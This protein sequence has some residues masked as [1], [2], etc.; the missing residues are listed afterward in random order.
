MK[1]NRVIF[2]WT[3]IISI[4]CMIVLPSLFSKGMFLDGVTYASISRNLA[5]GNGSILHPYYTESLYP[6]FHEQPPFFFLIQS[7]FFKVL[8]DFIWVERIFSAI[9]LIF[10]I[11]GIKLLWE[12]LYEKE[13]IYKNSY[14]PVLLFLTT[15]IVI[16][17]FQNNIIENLLIPLSIFSVYFLLLEGKKYDFNLIVSASL[18]VISFFTKGPVGLFPLT[19]PL[20]IW[21]F[22]NKPIRQ[23]LTFYLSFF[24]LIIIAFLVEDIRQNFLLFLE[25]QLF[26]AIAGKREVTT[27]TRFKIL[28]KLFLE[29][30][31]PISLTILTLIVLRNRVFLK[32][33]KGLLFVA[34]GLSASVPLMITLKQRSHYI[35]P[36]IPF[37][38]I[39]FSI[40]IM[41]FLGK[42]EK[43]VKRKVLFILP[44]SL[45]FTSISLMI[46][47]KGQ[48]L[49]DIK[50]Q[51]D[52]EILN[53][54]TKF[55][56]SID[57]DI[58]SDWGLHAYAQRYYQKSFNVSDNKTFRLLKKE[59]NLP[60]GFLS[61][62][63][64]LNRYQLAQKIN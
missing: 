20:F 23:F 18:L 52:L 64:K 34:I 54:K 7:F 32:N 8:G 10:S 35:L 2:F 49:R 39:G 22:L 14:L 45:F 60:K 28:Y 11:F 29:L 36:S 16:W 9:L 4:F 21:Y 15:P 62:D 26:P 13:P 12:K 17:S 59:K 48:K 5:F 55:D 44:L 61:T 3:L 51:I 43:H 33:G 50:L 6:K 30:L 25:N 46:S 40:F 37:F 47:N 19:V 41:P 63:I 38:I 27:N 31:F 58:Y 24:L 1:F 57:N 53:E 42:F 56:V